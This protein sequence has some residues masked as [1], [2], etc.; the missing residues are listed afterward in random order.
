MYKAIIKYLKNNRILSSKAA[1][2]CMY[3]V[4]RTLF[5]TYRL[6][7]VNNNFT[8][9]KN[10]GIYYFW[11]QDILAGMYFFYATK[12]RGYCI[13]SPSNDGRIIGSLCEKFGF[14]V[15]FGSSYKNTIGL[16]KQALDVLKKDNSLCLV[17]DGSRGPAH[18]LQ[19][20]IAYLAQKTTKP[21]FYVSCTASS[22]LQS[23]KSW[24]KFIFPLPFSTI[25][26]S[27]NHH[28]MPQ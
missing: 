25:T 27:I 4:I 5:A 23:K 22:Y 18:I 26:I 24:D 28:I 17:G 15:L 8:V 12:S 1:N 19:P 9:T 7:I 20:G 6:N 13:V 14:T 2:W 11:H 21:V 16:L 3:G 10:P